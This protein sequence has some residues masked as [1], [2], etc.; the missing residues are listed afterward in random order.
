MSSI[1]QR[2]SELGITL[3]TPVAPVANYVG[4]KQAGNLVHVS[5]QLPI[6]DGV[7][8]RGTVGVDL[9]IPEGYDAARL[10]GINL[11]AQFKAACGGDWDRLQSV[12]KLCGFVQAGPGFDDVPKVVNGC[13][14]LMVEVFGDRGRHARS[15]VGVMR[16]PMGCAVEV[17][18]VIMIAG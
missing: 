10:C 11:I 18:A 14:D 4:F 6:Q 12:V 8:T 15:A 16:L 2:L 17:E 7:G 3:P 13:S 9:N 1:E 5:G